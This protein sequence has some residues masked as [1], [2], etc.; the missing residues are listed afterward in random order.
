[1]PEHEL[2]LKKQT[3]NQTTKS[4]L[5]KYQTSNAIFIVIAFNQFYFNSTEVSAGSRQNMD[6]S[7]AQVAFS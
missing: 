2:K 3:Q 7:R 4:L 6:L 5:N 1:M